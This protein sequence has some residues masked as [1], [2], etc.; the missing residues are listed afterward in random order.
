MH[1]C[2]PKWAWTLLS[3]CKNETKFLPLKETEHDYGVSMIMAHLERKG[4][5][6][7]YQKVTLELFIIEKIEQEKNSC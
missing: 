7:Y 1:E 2:M 6:L 3:K 5:K 4:D